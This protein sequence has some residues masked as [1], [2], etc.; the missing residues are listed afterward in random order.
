MHTLPLPIPFWKMNGAGND[1]IIIDHRQPLVPQEK[2]AEF[3]RLLCRRKFSVGADGV[4]FVEPSTRADF[5][6]RFFNS[7]GSEAEMCGNGARC[8]ARFAYMQ[9]IAAA[10]MQFETLAGL[11]EASVADTRVAIR[12]TPPHSFL[13]DRQIEL[14]GQKFLVHSVDTG[15]PHAV[16]F[17]DNIDTIDVVGLGRLIRHHPDFAPAGT[18]VNFI[19]RTADG[20]RIRTYERGVEDETLACGTGA[21]AGALIAAAKGFAESPVAMI[22]SGGVALTVQLVERE[23]REAAMVLLRG[24]A[25]IVYKG[26]ITAEAF[27]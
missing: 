7:D 12:M 26:E 4:F 20:F 6:W 25:H 18:N 27:V 14:D 22:T 21:A 17:T 24:P 9:G 1:F 10:R 2:M 23:D 15:V 3:S 16:L 5:S 19:G 8:V 11:V 13:F